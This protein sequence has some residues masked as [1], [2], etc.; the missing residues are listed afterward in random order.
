MTHGSRDGLRS[1]A[2]QKR[3]DLLRPGMRPD[4]A[5]PKLCPPLTARSEAEPAAAEP[6]QCG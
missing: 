6:R 3:L 4:V 1:P 5:G 2:S